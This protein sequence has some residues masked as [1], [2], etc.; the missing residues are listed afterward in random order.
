MAKSLLDFIGQVSQ[1]ENPFQS[2]V[3]NADD[4]S[5][6]GFLKKQGVLP[7]TPDVGEAVGFEG[8]AARPQQAAV[9]QTPVSAQTPGSV[10]DPAAE[11][12]PAHVKAFLNATASGESSGRYDVRYTPQGGARFPLGPNAQHPGIMEPG[13]EGPS[14]AAGRYQF[15]KTTWDE[16]G[17]GP[18]HPEEQD[19]K[20]WQLAKQDYARR[21]GGDLDT[22][23]QQKGLTPQ[24]LQTLS[25]TWT[26]F[27]SGGKKA[28]MVYNESLRRYG[29]GSQASPS[30][31]PPSYNEWET[32]PSKSPIPKN[33]N[34]LNTYLDKTDRQIK[35][36]MQM[37][38]EKYGV[39][40][41]SPTLKVQDPGEFSTRRMEEMSPGAP[42]KEFSDV[43]GQETYQAP[44]FAQLAREIASL[45]QANAVYGRGAN[46]EGSASLVLDRFLPTLGKAVQH[47]LEYPAQYMK[48][49]TPGQEV[50]PGSVGWAKEVAMGLA[51]AHAPF[52]ATETLGVFGGKL[53]NTAS[54]S[55]RIEANLQ[56]PFKTPEAVHGDTGWFRGQDKKWRFEIDDRPAVLKPAQNPQT[57]GDVLD[58]PELYKA[59]PELKD[60]QLNVLS[61]D[62]PYFGSMER[63]SDGSYRLNIRKDFLEGKKGTRESGEPA[64]AKGII[65]HELQHYVQEKEGFASGA[66]RAFEPHEMTTGFEKEARQAWLELLQLRKDLF[67]GKAPPEAFDRLKT[68][69]DI[70]YKHDELQKAGVPLAKE[71]YNKSAGEVEARN[72]DR[73]SRGERPTFPRKTEDVKPNEQIIHKEP[74]EFKPYGPN[75]LGA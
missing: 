68:L 73:R 18:F 41:P 20:A 29:E 48:E 42:A 66:T 63:L 57:V 50:K 32:I 44:P 65:L 58:H 17:G 23:L 70:I 21:T 4:N 59:Y 33:T 16:M 26:S 36:P 2:L 51:G 7:T 13:P 47:I 37:L 61:K 27:R 19:V 3:D 11:G 53:A 1:G 67:A 14:S 64:D 55:K 10:G 8:G 72:V 45:R 39:L 52:A 6:V 62:Q 38:Q 15:T 60:M 69:Q 12:L 24:I 56:E 5:L 74:V 71:N 9:S 34:E 22:E 35:S 46:R 25:P 43:K 28:E 75:R 40:A 31:G 49:Y 30:A 54:T